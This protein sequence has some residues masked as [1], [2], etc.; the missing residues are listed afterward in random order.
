MSHAHISTSKRCF[1]LKSST[2]YFDM[3]TKILADFQIC[4]SVTLKE[5]QRNDKFRVQGFNKGCGFAILTNDTAKKQ[6][7]NQVKQQ[8]EKQTQQI[9]AR[10]RFR[11][12]FV[13]LGK[14]NKFINKTYFELYPSDPI[15]LR[16]CGTIKEL[17]NVKISFGCHSADAQEKPTQKK[18]SRPLFHKLKHGE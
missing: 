13:N 15:P 14:R 12:S 7:N 17:R 2:Y 16:L 3:K 10:P 18:I 5:L 8:Q 1:S 4:F 11:E 6:K 9:D